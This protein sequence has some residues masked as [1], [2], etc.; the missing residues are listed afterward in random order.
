MANETEFSNFSTVAAYV[1]ANAAPHFADE[2]IMKGLIT[3]EEPTLGSNAKK[4][5]TKGSLS[6]SVVGEGSAA[7]ISEYTESDVTL[8]LQKGVVYVELSHEAQSYQSGDKLSEL[9]QEAGR[10]L[11]EKFDTDVLALFDGF[12]GSVGSTGVDMS[13]ATFKSAAYNLRLNKVKGDIYCVMHPTQINDI[14]DDQLAETAT[15]YGNAAHQDLLDMRPKQMHGSFLGIPVFSS[16]NAESINAAADW[17]GGM[18]S[19]YAI[20]ALL[21]PQLTV[22]IGLDVQTSIHELSVIMD[23]QVGEWKDSAGI[24]IVSDQ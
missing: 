2:S 24:G 10:A 14:G 20:A 19:K 3:V 16:T 11:A 1:A 6:A 7:T 23:Y 17:S 5:P 18:F 21:K 8:T 9:A 22:N 4:F 15:I 13:P 12:S